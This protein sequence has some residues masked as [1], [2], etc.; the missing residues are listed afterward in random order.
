MF[1]PQMAMRWF[2]FANR[3]IAV[4]IK[5]IG[6]EARNMRLNI[7]LSISDRLTPNVCHQARA[8]SHVACM[9]LLGNSMLSRMAPEG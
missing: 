6:P 1:S 4:G 7:V 9:A 8:S 2:F 3:A 5:A